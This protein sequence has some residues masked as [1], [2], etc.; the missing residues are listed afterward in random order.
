MSS[1]SRR[2]M[3][4]GSSFQQKQMGPAP[5]FA[6]APTPKNKAEYYV[7]NSK[8]K[9]DINRVVWRKG[10]VSLLPSLS[11]VEITLMFVVRD[12]IVVSSAVR[13]GIS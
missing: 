1:K 7:Q 13:P 2:V 4:I 6:S 11:V 5:S 10:V 9:H 3:P 8:S 12:P